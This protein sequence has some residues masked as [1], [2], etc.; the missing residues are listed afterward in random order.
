[1]PKSK[2]RK[3]KNNSTGTKNVSRFHAKLLEQTQQRSPEQIKKALADSLPWVWY[4]DDE[5]R[6]ECLTD[7][8]ALTVE[9]AGKDQTPLIDAIN[10]WSE[11][12]E[13]IAAKQHNKPEPTK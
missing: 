3:K 1:M 11:Q 4:L 10:I 12:A 2:T 7:L 8:S 13:K 9:T 5:T 6:D